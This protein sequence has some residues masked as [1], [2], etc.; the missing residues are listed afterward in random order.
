M[1]MSQVEAAVLCD[2]ATGS[3]TP[4]AFLKE[5][6]KKMAILKDA[7]KHH[8]W[9]RDESSSEQQFCKSDAITFVL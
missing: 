2:E 6:K 9:C 4:F 7:K 8:A 3:S 5:Q 1:I